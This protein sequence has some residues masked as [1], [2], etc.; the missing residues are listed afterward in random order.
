MP[1][2]VLGN[3]VK[4][5]EDPELLVGVGKYVDDLPVEGVLFAAFARSP[6]PQAVIHSIDVKRA[7]E[8]PGVVAVYTGADIGVDSIPPPFGG[9]MHPAAQRP[10]LAMTRARYAS[11]PVVI[12][13]AQT[14]AEAEDATEAVEIDWEP[15]PAVTDIEKAIAPGA[16]LQFPE[17]G[18]NLIMGLRDVPGPDPLDGAD[19][20]VR[21]RFENQR[22]AVAPMEG[23]SIAVIPGEAGDETEL[24][25]YVATQMPHRIRDAIGNVFGIDSAAIHVITPNVGGA[26]GGKI[27]LPSEYAAVVA[28]ARLVNR[29]VKWFEGRSENLVGM[30]GRSQ[31]QYGELG[32]KRDGTI[33]GLKARAIG[34]SGAYGGFGGSFVVGP[35]RN[36]SQGVYKIPVISFDAAVAMTNTSPVGAFRGA[37]RPE[38]ASFIERL[39]DMGADELGIDPAELR[40]RNLIQPD[41]FPYRTV[42]GML[43]DIGNYELPLNEALRIADYQGLLAEQ[44]ARRERGDRMLLGIGLSTYVEITAGGPGGEF[45]AVEV[46][47]D[48]SATVRVGTAASGQGHATAFS[49]IVSACL[50]IPIEKIRFLQ[51]DTAQVPRGGGTGGSRSLQI[52]GV[53][54]GEAAKIVLTMGLELAAE[55]LEADPAD[56]ELNVEGHLGIV[57]VPSRSLSWAELAEVANERGAVLAAQNDFV[58]P[59]PTFPFGAHVSV[60]EIDS[61]TGQVRPLRHVAVDDAGKVL[62]PLLVGGQQ[63]G[64]LA[65]GLS[66]ALWEEFRYDEEGNPVTGNF[67]SY[68]IPSAAETI[69]YEASNTETPTPYN[70]LGAKGIGESATIGATPAVQ[71]AVVDALSHLGVRHVDMP[72]TPE[73]VWRAISDAKAGR[74]ADPWREPPDV[75]AGL[76]ER[77]PP[78]PADANVE[79]A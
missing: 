14:L 25:V 35:T 21:G 24:T 77:P 27:G 4:R 75:F 47:P 51:A 37:G 36:M 6:Y 72:A 8:M 66:Q 5:V 16:P 46:H 39:M 18:T 1:G 62:N 32:F 52:G 49:S 57:G 50:G 34:D 69:T 30:H 73:R 76:P 43:Y 31:V 61:E 19:V 38:A 78:T 48:G 12:V 67:A 29:P 54:V 28:A 60:V 55:L 70:P 68:A 53:A 22:V 64:G 63:H 11:E 17:I 59:G 44:K 41:A 33:V 13:L 58:P 3:V 10:A 40:R 2:S 23:N 65:Q 26:F 9:P 45:G 7:K 56:L 74:L 79:T 71:N 42:T 20:V 15:I